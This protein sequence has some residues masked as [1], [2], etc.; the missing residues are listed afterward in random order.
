MNQAL[1]AYGRNVAYQEI[2]PIIVVSMTESF[3][4]GETEHFRSPEHLDRALYV[5][6]PKAWL[7]LC[8][9]MVMLAAVVAWAVL[10]EIST[11]VQA[12]GIILSRG[13]MVFDTVS[14]ADGRL[15]RIVP[16]AGD[17]VAEGDLVAEIFDAETMERYLGAVSLKDERTRTLRDREA[18]AMKEN[19]LAERNIVRHRA[20]LDKLERTGRQLVKK[21]HKR[22]QDDQA[23][24]ARGLIN[25]EI[26]VRGE[27]AMDLARRNLFDAMRRRDE[28]QAGDLRRRN[29]L[30]ARV[31]N[32]KAAHLEAERQVNELTALIKTWRILAP[33][34]GRVTEIMAQVGATLEP[35][36]SVLGIETG[37]EGLDALFYASPVDG[38][39][40]EAGMPALVSPAT[41]RREEFG[42]MIGTVERLSEFPATLDGMMAV[43]RNQ[44][45]AR[46]FSRDGPPY[47]GRVALTLDPSTVSGF[48]WTSPRAVDVD[49]TP[50]TLAAVEVE[51][52]R[53]PPIAL[54]VP[55]VKE[56]FDL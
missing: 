5:T 41:A 29:E 3:R 38:K 53:R 31:T 16:G 27:Q 4:N 19:A 23:L 50:G 6:T 44:D 45:L 24:L 28:L 37:G 9:L 30:T 7:A 11:H 54:V 12:E 21:L 56:T 17:I 14:S 34:S 10:G 22:L 15:A 33:V 51:V 8:T 25:R 1:V 47:T 2:E 42:S 13:G 26:V 43:L 52:S 18:E 49:I 40:I 36:Q 35:G 39:R 20:R 48:A 32:A 55:W 46:A